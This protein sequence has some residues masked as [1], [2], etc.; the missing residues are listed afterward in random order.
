MGLYQ[1]SQAK[2]MIADKDKIDEIVAKAIGDMAK[3][4]GSSMGPGGSSTLIERDGLSP[5]A[6]KDGV[7]IAKS[8]GMDRAEYNVVVETAKE[9]C[10]NT[11]KTAGDGTTTAIVLADAL[12]RNGQK[13]LKDRTKYN[14]QRFMNEIRSALDKVIV[15]Y[16][17][18]NSV[19]VSS[20][21]ELMNVATISA[22]G[23]TEIARAVIAA[24]NAAGDDGT[25][26]IEEAQGDIMRV[27][28]I[29][30]FIATSGLKDL[31]QA[32]PI[33]INDKAGQQVKLDKGI[34]FLYNGSINDLKVTGLVQD[35]LEEV[36]YAGDPLVIFAHDFSDVVLEKLGKNVKGGLTICPVKTPMSPLPNSKTMFLEDLAAYTGAEV[37]DPGNIEDVEYAGLGKIDSAKITMFE[38]V[39]MGSPDTERMEQRITELKALM[40]A[41]KSDYDRLFIKAAIGKLS[42]GISTIWVG[43]ASELEVREKKA[44]VEDAVEAV[45]SAIA[46]GVVPGG[47]VTHLALREELKRSPLRK[48]SWVVLEESLASPFGLLMTNC[49]EEPSDILPRLLEENCANIDRGVLPTVIFDADKHEY[50]V[51]FKNGIIEPAKVCRVSVTNAISVAGLLINLRGMVVVPRNKGLEDQLALSEK[52]FKDMMGSDL[53]PDFGG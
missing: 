35:A 34:V 4:V 46:E 10:I 12:V 23:D 9:I 26:L 19:K 29:D 2:T 6:T 38:T 16:L 41:A 7:T 11:A 53:M 47:C 51:A 49:G 1:K 20:D 37:Y 21:E 13:F 52:A 18:K 25:V 44:R 36:G 5:L 22:N 43:A 31:G 40:S 42:G 30:G 32:G 14:P 17:A 3:I 39:L 8:L 48:D 27:E 24:V 28:T 45:R 33:F 15:P 50:A